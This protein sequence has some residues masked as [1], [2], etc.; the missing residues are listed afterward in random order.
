MIW[1]AVKPLFGDMVRVRSGNVYH[2]GIFVSETEII[3]FGEA[4]VLS[5]GIKNDDIKVCVTDIKGFLSNSPLEVALLDDE[6]KKNAREC[7]AVVEYARSKIG[8]TGYNV[9]HNNCE[10]FAH[11]C[12]FGR[13]FSS[14]TESIRNMFKSIPIVDL[15]FAKLPEN[16]DY[17]VLHPGMRNEYVNQ[18]K[19]P[20]VKRQRYYV[21]KLLEYA[22]DRSFGIKIKELDFKRN[23]KGKWTT[24]SC[25]FSVSHGDNAVAVAVSRKS[26][27]VDIEKLTEPKTEGFARK[28]LSS[29]EMKEYEALSNDKQGE[30][31]I[32]KWTVK[33]SLF[34]LS[35]DA[36]F[37]PSKTVADNNVK[38]E[39]VSVSFGDKSE[40]YAVSIAS[41]DIDKLRIYNV[42]ENRF[43]K[44]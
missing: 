24:D 23:E 20:L 22:L 18:A 12:L 27:G 9:I 14:Q 5:L 1:Q 3:Q 15:Y 30:Y 26:V 16:T 11:E 33:E 8:M 6:E 44:F 29:E 43:S 17:E 4:P 34:K 40:K 19:H 7:N 32:C 41:H 35:D 31:L 28:I 36:V 25:F 39:I 2:Y 37:S 10:H 38:T 21:W 13:K 42:D